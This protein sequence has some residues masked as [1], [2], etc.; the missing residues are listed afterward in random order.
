M[1]AVGETGERRSPSTKLHVFTLVSCVTLSS[2]A[3]HIQVTWWSLICYINADLHNPQSAQNSCDDIGGGQ[4]ELSRCSLLR[5]ASLPHLATLQTLTALFLNTCLS[6][7]QGLHM[8]K[9]Q[10]ALFIPAASPVTVLSVLQQGGLATPHLLLQM[11]RGALKARPLD[12][13]SQNFL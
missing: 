11:E 5:V 13:G 7:P 12:R 8:S 9:L 4:G 3:G 2:K 10:N 1:I 6:V